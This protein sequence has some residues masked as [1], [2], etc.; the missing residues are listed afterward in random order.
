METL[1]PWHL[2]VRDILLRHSIVAFWIGN[3]DTLNF[4]KFLYL[5]IPVVAFN[6][7][8]QYKFMVSRKEI[9]EL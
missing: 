6:I 7:F 2:D 4:I 5:P 8:E 9:S 3:L 1:Y